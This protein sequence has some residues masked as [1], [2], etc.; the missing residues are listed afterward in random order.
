M[1]GAL[2]GLVLSWGASVSLGLA[3]GGGFLNVALL[4]QGGSWRLPPCTVVKERG[5]K[6]E[7]WLVDLRGVPLA[8]DDSVAL[9]WSFSLRQGC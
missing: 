5:E 6:L 7:Y 1:V 3:S 2:T 4:G 9:Q 8:Y